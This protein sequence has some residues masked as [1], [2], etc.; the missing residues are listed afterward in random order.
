MEELL[1]NAAWQML[2]EL[3]A[4]SLQVVKVKKNGPSLRKTPNGI[5]DFAG[6]MSDAGR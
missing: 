3:R 1:A 4:N 6:R 5:V 2:E